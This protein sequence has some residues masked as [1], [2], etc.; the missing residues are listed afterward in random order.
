MPFRLPHALVLSVALHLLLLAITAPAPAA[1]PDAS[2]TPAQLEVLLKPVP[3]V[4][5]DHL[6]KD[7]MAKTSLSER[8][9]P[10]AADDPL[11]RR[12]AAARAE[13]RLAEHV[14]YPQEAI[15]RG[16]EGEVRL[17]VT[18]DADGRITDV[19]VAASSG[20]ALLDQAAV[21]AARSL[22]TL[23][24]TGRSEIFLPVRFQLR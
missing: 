12:R 8:S 13:R 22:G 10:A 14:Y 6:L 7:T 23:P 18:L 4:P 9:S 15:D 20:H 24:G 5:Q 16:L 11:A 2:L 3:P 19:Q 17:L 21:Q 1:R